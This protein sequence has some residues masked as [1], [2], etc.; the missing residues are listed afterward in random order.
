M[1]A[2]FGNFGEIKRGALEKRKIEKTLVMKDFLKYNQEISEQD[3]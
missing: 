1:L 2:S 3:P